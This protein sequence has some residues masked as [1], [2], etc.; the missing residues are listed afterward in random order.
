MRRTAPLCGQRVPRRR[1]PATTG[2]RTGLANPPHGYRG[3]ITLASRIR[4]SV[5]PQRPS[6]RDRPGGGASAGAGTASASRSRPYTG[7]CAGFRSY[8][9][10]IARPAADSRVPTRCECL[11]DSRREADPRSPPIRRNLASSDWALSLAASSRSTTRNPVGASKRPSLAASMLGPFTPP[12]S[13]PRAG[14]PAEAWSEAMDIKKTARRRELRRHRQDAPGQDQGRSSVYG[15]AQSPD[16]PDRDR[17]LD[18]GHG[19]APGGQD[20]AAGGASGATGPDPG[21]VAA[22]S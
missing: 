13:A 10:R 22:E 20:R 16:H 1:R 7:R 19:R 3:R 4:L 18:R 5:R 17:S 12:T 11:Q 2:P 15:V 8:P 6:E 14:Y 21:P 9:D